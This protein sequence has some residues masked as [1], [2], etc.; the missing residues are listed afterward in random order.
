MHCI[1]DRGREGYQIRTQEGMMQDRL[2][3][4]HDWC[5]TW[6]M[7]AMNDCRTGCLACNVL[8][9]TPVLHP[10]C[11][12]P[13][14][15][16]SI[17]SWTNPVLHKLCSASNPSCVSCVL[18]VHP[19]S[20]LSLMSCIHSGLGPFRPEWVTVCPAYILA[21]MH[22]VLCFSWPASHQS[23]LASILSCILLSCIHSIKHQPFHCINTVKYSY[24]QASI[25]SNIHLPSASF[26]CA[27]FFTLF[28]LSHPMQIWPDIHYIL[29][30]M[31]K[32]FSF[33]MMHYQ[34][35]NPSA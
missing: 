34:L 1:R 21:C 8:P 32:C 10:S 18:L 22:H 26:F 23:C 19:S 17:L 24:C 2:D 6:W 33:C 29:N 31:Q 30:A 9:C 14:C 11:H 20:P 16:A 25:L 27:K 15:P 5:M 7:H 28:F 35:K 4:R 13:L 3:T 12:A